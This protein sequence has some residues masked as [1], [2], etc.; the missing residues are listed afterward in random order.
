MRVIAGALGGRR[1]Q[2]PRG[3]RTRPTSDRVRE[4]IFSSLGD[5]E[6]LCV[7]DLYAGSGALG[8]EALSRGARSVVFV[9]QAKPAIAV[10]RA[11]LRDLALEAR[12]EIFATAVDRALRHLVRRRF[13]LLFADPPYAGL[14][15]AAKSLAMLVSG[16]AAVAV[17]ARL[18]LEHASRDTSPPI[19]GLTLQR[20][21]KYGDTAV[22]VYVVAPPSEPVPDC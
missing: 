3:R 16:D 21:R 12:S 7:L 14:E 11:N 10:L 19:A 2:A 9:E 13:D 22:A 15:A 18:V 1:I 20:M 6:D 4:A 17:G 8:I 5:V